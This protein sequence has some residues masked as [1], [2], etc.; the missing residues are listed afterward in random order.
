ME[1]KSTVL[2]LKFSLNSKSLDF[3]QNKKIFEKDFYCE[4]EEFEK[5]VKSD[6][7]NKDWKKVC[8][9]GEGS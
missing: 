2:L 3:C 8:D 5:K 1:A 7:T 4:F 9:F 6:Y